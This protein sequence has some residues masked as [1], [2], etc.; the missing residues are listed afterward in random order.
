MCFSGMAKLISPFDPK[1]H[2]KYWLIENK[3][4]G[5]FKI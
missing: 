1:Y 5:S 2:F 4:F 3:W